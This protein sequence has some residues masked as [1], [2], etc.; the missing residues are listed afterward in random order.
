MKLKDLVEKYGEYEVAPFDYEEA[1]K[2]LDNDDTILSVCIDV[3]KKKSKTVWD[4]KDGDRYFVVY[5][6]GEIGDIKFSDCQNDCCVV[7]NGNAFLA[8]E[9]AEQDIERRKVETLLLKYGGRRWFKNHKPN[10]FIALENEVE[11]NPHTY[12]A[13]SIPKQGAIYFDSEE[14]V[15]KAIEEIGEERIKKALFEVR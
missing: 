12:N 14:A 8:K 13:T 3:L 4:L 2:K 15:E 11:D 5:L 6:T 1:F 7:S 9:E 10:W